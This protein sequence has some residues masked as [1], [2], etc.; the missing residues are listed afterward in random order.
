MKVTFFPRETGGSVA[1]IDR[2][3]GVRLRLWSYDRKSTVPHDLAHLVTERAFGLRHGLWGSIADGA[4]FDSMDVVSGR[5]RH[6]SHRRSASLRKANRRELGLSELLTGVVHQGLRQNEATLARALN[7]TWGA[8]REGPCPYTSTQAH[9][10]VA[11]LAA[12]ADR[13][14]AT[15]PVQGLTLSWTHR[16]RA[17]PDRHRVRPP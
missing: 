10:A 14:T 3:D 16:R 1:V 8:L 9:A 5:L 17:G 6:D 4:M 12:L 13:W 7:Q 15:S 11:E 2:D